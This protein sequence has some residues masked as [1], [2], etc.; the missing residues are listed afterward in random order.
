MLMR[1]IFKPINLYKTSQLNLPKNFRAEFSSLVHHPK[2]SV[3]QLADRITSVVKRY[4]PNPRNFLD[5][6]NVREKVKLQK[7]IET[8]RADIKAEL[9]KFEL[10]NFL[11][12]VN[13][14]KNIELALNDQSRTV[15]N[16]NKGLQ[17]FYKGSRGWSKILQEFQKV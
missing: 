3:Q 1:M 4:V 7:F 6:E 10:D 12:V 5:L 2:E 11:D 13:R 8:L 15:N 16:V 14:T 17:T 9:L